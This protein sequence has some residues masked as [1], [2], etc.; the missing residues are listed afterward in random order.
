MFILR[1]AVGLALAYVALVILAWRFQDRLAF[2]APRAPLPDPKRVGVGNGER[3]ELVSGDGTR[4]AGW[5]LRAVEDGGGRWKAVKGGDASTALH[6]PSPPFPALLWFYGNGE[7]IAAIWPIVREF[8][9]PGT[10]VL[11]VDY[12]GYGGSAGRATEAAMYAAADAAYAAL[13]ARPGIDPGRIYVYG[14]SLGTAAATWVGARHRVAGV[15]LESPFTSAAAMAR[16]HYAL[17]PRFILR[18]SLDN[19]GRMRQIHCPV[20]VFHGDADRLVPTAMGRVVAAAAAGPVELVLIHGAGHNE[21]YDIGGREY[22]KKLW[23]FVAR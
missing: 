5:Y 19:L 20:L 7:T 15:I 12:P 2:P 16:Q 11:V 1:I 17:V 18:L 14:R 10:A 22:R 21:T 3:V 8:Q 6:R 4:L 9:P 23:E 13:V